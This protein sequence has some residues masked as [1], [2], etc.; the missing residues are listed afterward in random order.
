MPEQ[1][2][3]HDQVLAAGERRLDGGCLAGEADHLAH[4][5]GMGGGVDAGHAQRALVRRQQRGD[6][7]HERGLAGAVRPEDRRHGSGR[8][9]EVQAVEGDDGAERLAEAHGLDGGMHSY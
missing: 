6:R 3:H 7:P 5:L 4:P 9:D 1:P 8:G 2:G